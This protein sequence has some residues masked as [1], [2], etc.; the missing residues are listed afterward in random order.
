[1][2]AENLGYQI[3]GTPC[4]SGVVCL[5]SASP[6]LFTRTDVAVMQR[7]ELNTDNHLRTFHLPKKQGSTSC[8]SRGGLSSTLV[9]DAID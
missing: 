3:R 4:Y 1:V 7:A 2:I 6:V 9:A 5:F 8:H